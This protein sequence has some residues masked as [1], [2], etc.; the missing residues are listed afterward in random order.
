[1]HGAGV[2]WLGK[3]GLHLSLASP[4]FVRNNSKADTIY[5]KKKDMWCVV[6]LV[7]V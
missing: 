6:F 7:F 1:M 2:V 3:H 5:L 4:G